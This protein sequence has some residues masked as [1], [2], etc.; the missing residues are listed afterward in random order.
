MRLPGWRLGLGEWEPAG[1]QA[2]E[3]EPSVGKPVFPAWLV[4]TPPDLAANTPA[5]EMT[6]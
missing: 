4:T 2:P 5:W 1:P 6:G 3:G